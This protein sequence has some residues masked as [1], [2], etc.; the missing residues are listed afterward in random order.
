MATEQFR[1][2]MLEAYVEMRD[3]DLF[4]SSFF[5]LR[6][7]NVFAGETVSV[8]IKRLGE[9][10]A[11]VVQTLTG[12]NYSASNIYTTKEWI[13]PSFEEGRKFNALELLKRQFG[14]NEYDSTNI[15]FQA[16]LASRILEGFNDMENVL[17]RTLEVQASQVLQTGVLSLKDSSGVVAF[18]VDF[19][20]KATHFPTA[21]I[22]WGTAGYDPLADI[23][24]LCDVIREDSKRDVVKVIMGAR[25]LD[26][27]LAN[28]KV[29]EQL[30]NRRMF[31]G[32]IA[33]AQ[34]NT[35]GKRIGTFIIGSYDVEI[36]TYNG[37]FEDLDGT[38]S[39]KYVDD[40]SV[41]CMSDGRMDKVFADVPRV[42][43]VDPRFSQFLPGRITVPGVTDFI[44]NIYATLNGK[45]LIE[46]LSMRGMMIPTAIDSFGNLDSGAP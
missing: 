9:Q 14:V 33:P 40:A 22:A 23:E 32:E 29:K 44:P 19:F 3:P 7:G 31:L 18:T 41:I 25:A 28:D 27:F 26:Q 10:I 30:D 13:P 39:Q 12:P 1:K 38:P 4:L 16:Q 21:G 43:P 36:W 15:S 46:E 8:D 20:P 2:R 37:R 6:P 35:G 5:T 42:T 34:Q 24:L 17:K 45:Q 11:A